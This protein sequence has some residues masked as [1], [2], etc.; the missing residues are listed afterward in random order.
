MPNG[1]YNRGAFQIATGATPLHT[2]DL[3][4]LLVKST[5]VFDKDHNFVADVVAG[6]L[7]ISVAGYARQ[8]LANEAVTEDDTNDR[9]YLDADDPTFTALVAGQTIGG[10]VIFRQ[11]TTDADSP[12]LFFIDL[13]D[14]P[15]N[16]TD[17]K[18]Q[19]A[20]PGSGGVA[21]LYQP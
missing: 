12:V 14:T 11:V 9:A 7:E 16:G 4:M 1:V 6:A 13:T 20:A 19:F 17:F 10:A 15:T 8:A 21:Y 5:Y 2:A 18:V 3:R